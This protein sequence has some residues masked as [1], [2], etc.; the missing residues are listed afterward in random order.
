MKLGALNQSLDN[1]KKKQK[2][3]I[4]ILLG[5]IILGL[6]SSF[7]YACG[8]YIKGGEYKGEKVVEDHNIIV[9]QGSSK[10]GDTYSIDRDRGKLE[11]KFPERPYINKFQYEYFT[12]QS[13]NENVKLHIVKEN[14]YGDYREEIVEDVFFKGSHRSVINVKGNVEKITLEL[15]EIE[16]D[17]M[18]KNF[19]VDNTLKWNP[20]L[21]VFV[22]STSFVLLFLIK[23]KKENAENPGFAVFV[24][25]LVLGTCL[26]ALQPPYCTGWDEQIHFEHAYDLAMTREVEGAPNSIHQ[27]IDNYAWLD[28]H[29][30]GSIEERVDFIKELNLL[31]ETTD[32]RGLYDYGISMS[33]I[34]YVFQAAAITVGKMLGLPFY[35][36]WLLGKF[37]NILL[38]AIGM[39]VAIWIVPIGKR[40]LSVMAVLPTPL[41]VSTTYTYDVTVNVF[42]IIGLCIWIR[43]IVNRDKIFD[44]KWRIIYFACMIIGC[45]PKAVYAPLILC[46][47][48]LPAS[49][50]KSRKDKILF[51]GLAAVAFLGMMSTFVLPTLLSPKQ[52]GDIRGGATSVATQ[53]SYVLGRPFAYA[54]VLI[55]N[56]R[57]TFVPYS[58]EHAISSLAY[59]GRATQPVIYAVLVPLVWI[60]DTYAEKKENRGFS[61]KDRSVMLLTIIMTICLIWTALYLDFTEVGKTRI[62]GVQGRYYLPFLF[63][64]YLCFKPSKVKNE[65]K[66]ENYQ[67]L[68][69]IISCGLFMVQLYQ[70]FLKGC[71]L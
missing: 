66:V 13:I 57:H 45:M 49:K 32:G 31:S 40:L 64:L 46:V 1:Y 33:G 23:F 15:P 37:T 22:A 55:E 36:I 39:G 28:Y 56:V 42:I 50:F 30:V 11:I 6:G 47:F 65:Y 21:A 70:I 44:V 3:M 17:L 67:M 16:N 59:M 12:E 8:S 29:H 25:V 2:L 19:V 4:L 58:M 41:F 68:V 38:Y 71:G 54:R 34:G 7:L 61:I 53:M 52:E 26:L 69:M 24:C 27:L 10:D 43:E 35:I 18:L 62:A 60:S 48:F 20:L 9:G 14:I 63:L 5:S 51:K